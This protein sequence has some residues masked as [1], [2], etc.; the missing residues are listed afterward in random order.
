MQNLM[1][2][3]AIWGRLIEKYLNI[4][5]SFLINA[6][7]FQYNFSPYQNYIVKYIIKCIMR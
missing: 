3:G 7:R 1:K 5:A 6:T 4:I 2:Y